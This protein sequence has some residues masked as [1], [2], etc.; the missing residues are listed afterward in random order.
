M[1]HTFYRGK[2]TVNTQLMISDLKKIQQV[3]YDDGLAL[4]Y[5]D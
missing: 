2:Q 1:D 4:D 3:K 5:A